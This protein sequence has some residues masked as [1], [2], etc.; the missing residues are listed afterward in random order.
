MN[1][2]V[3]DSDDWW[4]GF[5]DIEL[6]FSLEIP[7]I[8]KPSIN[9]KIFTHKITVKAPMKTFFLILCIQSR[10]EYRKTNTC[11]YC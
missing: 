6:I 4:N 9:K 7:V 1:G 5:V 8:T 11:F 3:E 2:F 10:E